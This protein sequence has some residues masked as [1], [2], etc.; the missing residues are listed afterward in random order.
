[1]IGLANAIGCV[2]PTPECLCSKPEFG[3]GVRDCSAQYCPAGTDLGAIVNYVS[4]YCASSGKCRANFPGVTMTDLRS[5]WSVLW[6]VLCSILCS[7]WWY[8][9]C[10]ICR[11][12]NWHR[13][14]SWRSSVYRKAILINPILYKPADHFSDW[15]W[16]YPQCER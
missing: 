11:Y 1:M 13:V 8:L 2:S 15:T 3:F 9:P 5:C 4:S 7:V 16:C 10:R 14:Y 12:C 6:S